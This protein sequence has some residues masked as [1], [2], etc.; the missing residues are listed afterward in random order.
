MANSWSGLIADKQLKKG[1]VVNMYQLSSADVLVVRL[2][3]TSLALD[4]RLDRSPFSRVC[5][6]L[7]TLA[8]A[9]VEIKS[10]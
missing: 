8:V 2:G 6:R 4:I 10:Q 3:Q 1:P 5:L 7:L 9:Q